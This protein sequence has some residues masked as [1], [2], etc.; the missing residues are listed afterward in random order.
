M[1]TKYIVKSRLPTK[2]G[3]FNV[4]AYKAKVDEFP[5]LALYTLNYDI[6]AVVDVRIHSECMTGDVFGSSKCDCGEQLDYSMKWVQEHEGIIIYLRQ[7]GRGIGLVNKLHAYNLQDKGFDTKQA[8]LELGF[9][10]DS[11]DYAVAIE[12]LHDLNI[13]EIRLLTNNPSKINAFD[14]SGIKIK[15][16][17]PIETRVNPDN[18]EYLRTKKDK[19]GHLLSSNIKL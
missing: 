8:N 1:K 16:R 3:E 18:I 9:H 6:E 2:F 10:E 13:K 15:E 14:N 5:N 17:I 12:I 11:R 7:E 4:K 19:M